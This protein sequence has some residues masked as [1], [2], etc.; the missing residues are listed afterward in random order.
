MKKSIL[1]LSAILGFLIGAVSTA[2]TQTYDFNTGTTQNWTLDQMYETSTQ[3]KITPFTSFWLSNQSNQLAASASP[4]LIGNA[5]VTS[6]DIYLQSP[7]LSSNSQWQ[8]IAGYSIDLK[9]TLGSPCGSPPNVYFVQLQMKVID[10][11]D[12]NK[13]KLFA[14]YNGT[15]FVFHEIKIGNSYHF[16]WKPSFLS[17]P[18]YKVKHLRIRLTGPGDPSTGECAPK[19]SWLLDN[20]AVVGG[21]TQ[22]NIVVDVPNGGE[23]WEAGTPHIIVWHSQNYNA[24]VKIEYSTNGGSSYS[25]IVASTANSGSYAW[26]V[27]NAPSTQCRVRVSD[28][29]SGTPSDVS[30]ANFT[31]AA[32][33]AIF[34][35][36]PDGGESWEAGTPHYIVW[37]NHLFSGAV[38][39]EYSTDGGSNY[40]TITTSTAN[41]GSYQ[42]TVPNTPSTQCR[43]RI[44]DT[45]DGNP[46]DVSDNNFT[47]TGT[48]TITLDVPNGG[49]NWEVGSPRIIVWHN[50]LFNGSVKIEYST[51]G[52]T[53]YSTIV[54]STPNSGSFTWTIPN[55]PSANCLVKVSDAADGNP[56][57]VSDNSFTISASAGSNTPTGSN[58]QVPL[59]SGVELTFDY[60][61]NAGTTTLNTNTTGPTPPDGFAVLPLGAPIFYDIKTTATFSG[62]VNPCIEYNPQGLTVEQTAE[63]MLK[64]FDENR[65]K[66]LG[67]TTSV[68][69]NA[70]I[71][72]GTVKHLST[73]AVMSPAGGTESITITQPNGNEIWSVGSEQEITWTSS[74][75]TGPVRIEYSIDGNASHLDVVSSTNKT[76]SYMWTIPNTPSTNCV[77]IISDPT[78]GVPF[79]ISDAVFSITT[80]AAPAFT[81]VAPNGGENLQPGSEYWIELS[82]VNFVDPVH[83]EY[84][85]DGGASFSTVIASTDNDGAYL[86][87]V[88][89]TASA[90]CRMKISDAADGD[91]F[92]VSDADFTISSTPPAGGTL[93]VVNTDDSGPGSLRDAILQAKAHPGPDT[94][95]FQIPQNV[96]G[97][98]A[99]TG[100]WSI[101]P[102][103]QL[104]TITDEGLV[105]DGL[106]QAKFTGKDNNPE[107]PEIEI[108]GANAGASAP[109]L[110]VAADGVEIIGLIINRFSGGASVYLQETHGCRVSACYL[111]TDFTGS[112]AAGNQYGVWILTGSENQIA[113]QDT[114]PNVISGNNN[115]GI[116]LSDTSSHNIILANIIGLT[117]DGNS[118]LGNGL[119]GI[120]IQTICDSN[121]VFDN[122]IGSNSGTGI[123]IY[124]S[125]GNVFGNN[126]IGT[127]E[128]LEMDFGNGSDGVFIGSGSQTKAQYNQ[129]MENSIAFNDA[130]GIEVA[131]T[132]CTYNLIRRNRIFHNSGSG[133]WNR[134]GGNQ[135]LQSPSISSVSA[136]AIS[137]TAPA[138]ATIDVFS[139]AEDEGQ[140]YLGETTA[141]NSGN[142]T[143]TIPDPAPEMLAN[144]TATATDV[145]GNTSEFSQAA[146][147][148]D[149]KEKSNI[150]HTF[151]LEE[152]YPNPFNPTTVIRYDMPEKTHVVLRVFNLLGKEVATLVDKEQGAGSYSVSW[153]GRDHFGGK[154]ASGVYLYRLEAGEFVAMKKMLL[155]K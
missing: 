90:N 124:N 3:N 30:H 23:V 71:I 51:N 35:D 48:E 55:T 56:W 38:K 7:D 5:S 128:T 139:D 131:G 93:T 140:T 37:H 15:S 95:R 113:P 17:D 105:I 103:T 120:T 135:E 32:N 65:G 91:P 68:D 66:W 77:V 19:G 80:A 20:V 153:D 151:S 25:T 16:V 76:G 69:V 122:R 94:I 117:K 111:G 54:A 64:V 34:V 136:A 87:T 50:H 44:S 27:P 29:A 145:S 18:K 47:I 60:V 22:K 88:P 147:I 84:S 79:D 58:I 149:V 92:D 89:N 148:T 99:D 154:V 8:N 141:D 100:V 43:V 134:M 155:L 67:I 78:D 127:N 61:S 24:T 119:D 98:D 4:I 46:S 59:G 6:Y 150:P 110:S 133:I 40:T 13:E 49:E 33:E 2:S 57:D 116:F 53:N 126:L 138:N 14:E 70:N 1:I 75:F 63:L 146:S 97:Y 102:Q 112:G 107:G 118:A 123:A 28:A 125:N 73:F 10:T 72:C 109:G 86:W 12:G 152:N 41:T 106:S 52:G 11:T 83:I 82:S 62:N 96:P 81:V 42:W 9:R 114:L 144:F 132:G 26:N 31:I 121:E 115:S 104:P 45:A 108:S 21:A 39:I 85:T 143:F 74:N 36:V 101:H 137:G 129:F 142:F 130:A